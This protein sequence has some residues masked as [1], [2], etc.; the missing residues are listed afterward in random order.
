MFVGIGIYTATFYTKH[1]DAWLS[2]LFWK[3]TLQDVA[4][5]LAH[6]TNAKCKNGPAYWSCQIG[7]QH[8]SKIQF[9]LASSGSN[10]S[11]NDL[12]SQMVVYF[13]VS[14]ATVY[15]GERFRD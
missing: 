11:R 2:F 10:V 1:F 7:T 14:T 6:L 9:A 3:A 15:L 12:S 13:P 8:F 5:F 4:P